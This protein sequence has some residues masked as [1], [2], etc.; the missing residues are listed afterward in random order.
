MRKLLLAVCVQLLALSLSAQHIVK[1]HVTGEAG[2]PLPG[3]SVTIGDLGQSTDANGSFVF[4][5]VTTSAVTLRISY[6]GYQT[7]QK[8]V[9]VPFDGKIVLQRSSHL[10]DEVIVSGVR[11]TDKSPVAYTNIDKETLSKSNL[12]QDVPYLLS[13]TPSFVATSDGGTGVGYTYFRI[14]GT[15]GSR[16]NVTVNGIPYNDADEQGTFWVDIPDMT[17]SVQSMQVQRGVGTSTN[18]AGAFG[19]N[20]N[21]QTDNYASTQSG[22]ANVSY[23]SFNTF[24]GTVK[25][26][27]GLMGGHWAVDTRLSAITSDGYI[28]RASV[29]MKSYFIQAGY[30]GQKTSLKFV[31]FGGTEKTYHAWDGVPA[32]SLS[33]HR[34]Y[35]PCGYMGND[36]NGNPLFYKNQTDNYTQTNYQLLGIHS[37]SSALTLNAGLHYTRGDGYYEEYKKTSDDDPVYLHNYSLPSFT[38]NGITI[39]TSDLVR[40]KKMGNDFAGGVFSLTYNKEKLSLQAGGGINRYWGNHWGEVIWVKNYVGN[41]LP[42]QE[43]Y[44]SAVSKWDGNIYLKAN[45]DLLPNLN[46]YGDVQ[47]RRVTYSLNGTND[48]WDSSINGMQILDLN[49]KFNFFNPKAGLLYRPNANNEV[50]ASVAVA[51]REPTRSNYTDAGSEAMPAAETLYDYEIGYLFKDKRFSFG[52]NLYYMYYKNQLIL[53]GKASDI[54]EML[55]SNIPESYRSGIELTAG[56]KITGWLKWDANMTLS[57][58][59][60]KHFTE[61]VDVYDASWHWID[62]KY[63]YL[64]TTDISYS[65]NVTANSIFTLAYKGF[66]ARLQSSYVGKQY[67]DNTSSNDRSIASYLVNN[68]RLN[69]TLKNALSLKEIGFSIALNN[70]LNTYYSSNGYVWYSCYLDNQRYNDLRY[71]PQAGFNVLAGISVKF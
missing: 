27:T 43:Y 7:W 8:T 62:S 38:N 70:L 36:A 12:G 11:A 20:I 10:M 19:A 35:N 64:G 68:L 58:N 33:T 24:K 17:S 34:T 21:L 57:R 6:I 14:R 71:F 1:G 3:A 37:F 30:Y 48:E 66:E 63:N 61:Y 52:A 18:G 4:N 51:H 45:Y 28:D 26:S 16:I 39:T 32:D 9:K 54:G 22:E 15:D 59:K 23:G 13:Q 5:A 67:M 40:Q 69:Y 60:I 47:Y 65:P 42:D 50:F 55:T 31:T 44:R 53:T 46:V 41:L 2:E 49:K 56:V 25:A 29:N